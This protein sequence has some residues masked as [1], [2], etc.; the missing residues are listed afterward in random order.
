MIDLSGNYQR[1]LGVLLAAEFLLIVVHRVLDGD[2]N[3]RGGLSAVPWHFWLPLGLGIYIA[4]FV[5][6]LRCPNPNCKA[7]QIYGGI[8]PR[9]WRWPT[10]RCYRCGSELR[11]DFSEHDKRD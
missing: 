2:F 9:E 1:K 10:D 5:L 6:T 7:P 8:N 3:F 11:A 4:F